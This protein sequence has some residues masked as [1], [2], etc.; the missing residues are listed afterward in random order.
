VTQGKETLGFVV[1]GS[2]VEIEFPGDRT[3]LSVLREDLRLTGAK[4]GCSKG[5][6]GTCAVI[7][8]GKIVLSCHTRAIEIAG[9]AVTTIEGIGTR[10]EPHPLQQAFVETGA[11]Q[12]G[13]CTPG[14]I[15]SAKALLDADAEPTREQIVTALNRHLCRCTGYIKLVEAVELAAR[16]MRGEDIQAHSDTD[17]ADNSNGRIAIGRSYPRRDAWDKVLGEAR[18]AADIDLPG[19]HHVQVI[20]SPH[21][22][23]R[24][25]SL[26]TDAARALPGVTAVITAADVPGRNAVA[27]FRPDQPRTASGTWA[28]RW[29]WWSPRRWRSLGR[30]AN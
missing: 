13:Y 1:N 21:H 7:V 27:I 23:A 24:I 29:L 10:E 19:I 26:S 8:D 6:C 9:S 15:L 11:V 16:R 28:N 2:P 4:A 12:C 18:F 20:R 3:L 30:A 17:G 14:A 22:H 5:H 25:V